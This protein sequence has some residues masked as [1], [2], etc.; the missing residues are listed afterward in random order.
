MGKVLT[1]QRGT[2]WQYRFEVAKVDNKRKYVSKGGFKTQKE[3][4]SAGVKAKAEYDNC[5]KTF[6]PS[7]LSVADY[8]DYYLENYAKV[9]CTWGTYEAYSQIIKNHIKPAIG[10][11]SL[12]NL[13]PTTLQEFINNKYM[14]GF[15]KNYLKNMMGLLTSALRYAVFP[16]QFI[17]NDITV[18]VK[19]P[20]KANIKHKQERRS[21][22][23][24]EFK[25]II[26]RFP[27]GSN[28]HMALMIGYYTGMRIGE[29]M[30]LRWQDIDMEKRIIKVD[31]IINKV[32]GHF[33]ISPPKTHSSYREVSFGDSLYKLLLNWKRSQNEFKL[34]CGKY[35]IK[36]YLGENNI[37]YQDTFD[38]P[39][40]L[41]LIHTKPTGEMLTIESFKYASK[42][43]NYELGIEFSFHYLRH[44]HATMLIENGAQI[45]DVSNR[46]GH[47]SVK[48]TLETYTHNTEKMKN[49]TVELF[50]RLTT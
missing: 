28:H 50:E 34:A 23:N 19:I 43:I 42:V 25:R 38:H 29:V 37:I 30:G 1:R 10:S 3:A 15:S 41:D 14:Q 2:T 47:S 49:E 44:T 6:A 18:F 7:E 17:K 32:A 12:K 8:F 36:Q 27:Y 16:C 40:K 33:V 22:S 21:I 45:K 39:N 48:T 9:N 20:K 4:Y 13:S 31:H 5:G 35:Y 46:L 26:E 11:Y 24:Q